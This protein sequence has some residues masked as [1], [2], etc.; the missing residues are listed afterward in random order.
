MPVKNAVAGAGTGNGGAFFTK[1]FRTWAYMTGTL[2]LLVFIVAFGVYDQVLDEWLWLTFA[3]PDLQRELGF[4]TGVVPVRNHDGGTIHLFGITSIQPDGAFGRAGFR[5]GDIP[6]EWLMHG[7]AAAGF[8]S[9]LE[10]SRGLG[11]AEF[12]VFAASDFST[13]GRK[14]ERTVRVLVPRR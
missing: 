13:S 12:R 8:Y 6:S 9:R 4:R 5:V 2:M 14:H 11:P 10:R 1:P 7:R 3:A